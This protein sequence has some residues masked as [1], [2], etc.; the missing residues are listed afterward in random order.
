MAHKGKYGGKKPTK[1]K[2]I[3]AIK[4]HKG[5]GKSIKGRIKNKGKIIF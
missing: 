4:K 2:K 5:K 3:A 1:K